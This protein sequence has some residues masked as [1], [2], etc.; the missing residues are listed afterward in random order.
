MLEL[1]QLRQLDSPPVHPL[2]GAP[3]QKQRHPPGI[4]THRVRG[5]IRALRQT[6]AL[7]SR[8]TASSASS[9]THRTQDVRSH[10]LRPVRHVPGGRLGQ[11]APGL[12]LT[13]QPGATGNIFFPLSVYGGQM[14]WV[15]Q[16]TDANM[17]AQ[18]V[19]AARYFGFDGWFVNQETG[20]GTS[21]LLPDLSPT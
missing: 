21:L 16:F 13:P 2:P 14:A 4:S 1:G 3:A 10:R 15:K 5:P 12:F 17:P 19:R 8:W 18:L 6:S 11:A 7:A 9:T 20:G